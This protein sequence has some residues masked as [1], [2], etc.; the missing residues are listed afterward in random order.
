MAEPP[1]ALRFMYSMNCQVVSW[2][3]LLVRSDVS[4]YVEILVDD[5]PDPGNGGKDFRVVRENLA[6]RTRTTIGGLIPYSVCGSGSAKPRPA[7]A[8]SRYGWPGC[9]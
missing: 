9:R 2:T 6:G 5:Q 7:S 1:M 8:G 3:V 4:K